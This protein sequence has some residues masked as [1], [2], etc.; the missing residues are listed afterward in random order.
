M[1]WGRGGRRVAGFTV[2]G[3]LRDAVWGERAAGGFFEDIHVLIVVVLGMSILLGSLAAAYAVREGSQATAALRAE[4]SRILRAVLQD[5]SLVH[6]GEA[7]LLDLPAIERLNSSALQEMAGALHPVLLVI[8]ERSGD[9]PRTFLV[10]TSS[11]GPDRVSVS[12]A[13]DVWHSDLEVRGARV[14]ITLGAS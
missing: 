3:A 12:T 11:L 13:A 6:E 1:A 2:P 5:E 9:A 8:A 10:Q 7:G 4:A 14:T